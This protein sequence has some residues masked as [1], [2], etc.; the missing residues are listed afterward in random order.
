MAKYRVKAGTHVENG[1]VYKAGQVVE[2]D[3]DLTAIFKEKF[4]RVDYRDPAP[5]NAEGST[6]D[7]AVLERPTSREPAPV[8]PLGAPSGPVSPEGKA[9]AVAAKKAAEPNW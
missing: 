5:M 1:V 7:G 9:A 2:T 8:S 6:Q 3:Q 4:E